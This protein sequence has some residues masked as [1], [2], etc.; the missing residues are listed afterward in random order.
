MKA[1]VVGD[2]TSWWDGGCLLVFAGTANKARVLA[3]HAGLYEYWYPDTKALR[4]KEFDAWARKPEPHVVETND[5]L[6]EGAPLF[7]TEE[8]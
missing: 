5:D 7:Y 4:Y 8:D 6:A 1:F 2:R 3:C